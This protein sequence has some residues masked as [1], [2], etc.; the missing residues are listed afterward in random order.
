AI[1]GGGVAAVEMAFAFSS[2]GAAVTVLSR[3]ALLSR[4]EPFA[5]QLVAAALEEQGAE[6]RIGAT[7]SKMSRD[8]QGVGHLAVGEGRTVAAGESLVATGCRASS[9]N[10]GLESLGLGPAAL[11]VDDT[12]RD[13][14]TDWL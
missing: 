1:I 12:L 13:S 4:E 14:G 9:S 7:P 3:G 10:L 8:A 11:D 5:G 6:V 2:L